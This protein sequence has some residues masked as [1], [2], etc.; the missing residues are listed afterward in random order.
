MH[1]QKSSS[2]DL[3]SNIAQIRRSLFTSVFKKNPKGIKSEQTS[4]NLNH[5]YDPVGH[6]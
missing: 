4:N 6:F 2:I 1:I 3:F 5:L